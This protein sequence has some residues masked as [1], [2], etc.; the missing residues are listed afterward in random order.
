MNRLNIF[1]RCALVALVCGTTSGFAQSTNLTVTNLALSVAFKLTAYVQS[2]NAVGQPSVT[3]MKLANN[4]L[5]SALGSDLGESSAD[6]AGA[7]LLAVQSPIG[8]TNVQPDVNRVLRTASG[9]TNVNTS[10]S[11]APSFNPSVQTVRGATMGTKVSTIYT[12]ATLTLTTT[13]LSFEVK[14]E[15]KLGSKA[16]IAGKTLIDPGPLAAS[17][18][19]SVTGTGT[20]GTNPAVFIGTFALTNPKIETNTVVV[21]DTNSITGSVAN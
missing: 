1:K 19:A 11:I 3:V 7:K 12:P 16:V 6:L 14:G 21:P 13:N 2:T 5:I 4:D 10:F 9:D 8:N 18:S 17:A 20:V 15:F